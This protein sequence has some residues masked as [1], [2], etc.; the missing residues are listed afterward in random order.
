MTHPAALLRFA[1]WLGSLVAVACLPARAQVLRVTAGD[2]ELAR[3][4]ASTLFGY[5]A[6]PVTLLVQLGADVKASRAEVVVRLFGDTLRFRP[7][8]PGFRVNGRTESLNSWTYLEDDVLFVAQWFFTRWLPSR[9]PERLAYRDG[10][11]RIA[12][13]PKPVAAARLVAPPTGDTAR[14]PA[15][16]RPAR[17][18]ADP[19]DPLRGALLGFI[20]AR[21]SGVFDSNVDRDPV[22][23][24][25]Y[26]T[27]V[28]LGAGIQSARSRPFLMARYDFALHR[29]ANT[30]EWNRATHDV[31]AEVA[32]SLSRIRLRLGA[33]VRLKSWTE[34]R[35]RA[36]QVI[37][38][39]QIEF[40][41]APIHVL[42]LYV[43]HSAR[44][45]DVASESRSDT[46]RLAGIG[47][48]VWL[49]GSG[50][51]VDGRYEENGSELERSRHVGW[52]GLTWME[53]P[54]PGSHRLTLEG[55]HNRRRYARSF[56]DQARTVAR[57]DRR[58]TY[59]M[60]LSREL[61]RTPWELGLAYH[62]EGNRSN[63][64][65]AV[66]SGRRVEVTVRRRW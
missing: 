15:I 65:Y 56:V 46:F 24:P 53:I 13:A 58:W 62:F 6:L 29:F 4:E 19:D 54:L 39:P 36:D 20:D 25:S 21:V 22:P 43:L 37:L 8:H 38:K 28:R 3:A 12:A 50:V 30:E 9:Y 31:S 47:Y 45:I 14:P 10:V 61:A 23:R 51:R 5:A 66:Y 17:G 33:A 64:T 63:D 11:L 1:L 7:G 49:H 41:P 52:T 57:A 40:R 32:P 16:V 34:D 44:R 60:S 48:Y 59:S 26:G 18:K 42:Y 35:E 2:R 55:T 27:V